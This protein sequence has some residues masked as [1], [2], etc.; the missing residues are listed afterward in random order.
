MGRSAHLS[1]VEEGEA[2]SGEREGRSGESGQKGGSGC[3]VLVEGEG[4]RD[5]T[6]HHGG[7]LQH[8]GGG[9]GS[10]GAAPA[11]GRPQRTWPVNC[12]G[13]RDDFW[14]WDVENNVSIN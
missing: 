2:N 14:G 5:E 12:G 8:V 13:R 9:G 4:T 3:L 6:G 10:T 11:G 7:G 1:G